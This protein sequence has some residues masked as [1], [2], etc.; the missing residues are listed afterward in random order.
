M[1]IVRS[2]S[3]LMAIWAEQVQPPH[4]HPKE[5]CCHDTPYRHWSALPQDI[6]RGTFQQ[7]APHLTAPLLCHRI[8]SCSCSITSHTR[9]PR[10]LRSQPFSLPKT[11]ST[12]PEPIL[13]YA[14]CPVYAADFND[15]AKETHQ[16]L[17]FPYYNSPPTLSPTT[18]YPCLADRET[19]HRGAG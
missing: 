17:Y 13:R 1:L 19:R 12:P 5:D 4:G 16:S 14:V 6:P 15:T 7:G 8:T 9:T 2:F 18:S 10:H 3:I 11:P